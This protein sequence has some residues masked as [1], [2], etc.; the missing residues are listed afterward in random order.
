MNLVFLSHPLFLGQQS[1]PRFVKMLM[2][3]MARRGHNGQ[4]WS[5]D[6]TFYSLSSNQ[7]I[8]KWLGYVDQY[9]VFP[10]QIKRKKMRCSEDTLFVF[11]DHALGPWVPFLADRHHVIHCHDFLAQ[12]SALG[13]IPENPTG[14]TGSQYQKFIHRGY[15]RGK[16][17]ISVSQKTREDLH[18][19]LRS[20]PNLSEMVYNG[21][22]QQFLPQ[23]QTISRKQLSKRMGL[24]LTPGY[25]LHVGGNPWYK[26]RG[27]VIEIYNAWRSGTTD[28]L[29][30]LMVGDPPSDELLLVHS[31]SP[32]RNDIHWQSGIEDEYVRM[33]YAGAAV[34]LFPSFAEGFGWPIA[35]AMASGCPVITTNEAPMTEVAGDAGFLIPRR[36]IEVNE[37][38]GWATEAAAVVNKILGFS[39]EDRKAT[40]DAGI[41]N[42]KR[43]D[44]EKALDLIESIYKRILQAQ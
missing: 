12:K 19:F 40:I 13:L 24:N 26:N 25:L 8:K 29:P 36:P 39:N 44:T 15:S 37:V 20:K 10:I 1:M 43:F 16:N 41:T 7:T 42:A 34:F 27:G 31:L 5:P 9:I 6:S 17:F 38:P 3:G 2:D 35:E 28:K 30:L 22:N 18:Q 11:T 23:D 4:V 21:L 33:A 14:W 32:F